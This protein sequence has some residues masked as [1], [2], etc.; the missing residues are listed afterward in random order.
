MLDFITTHAGDLSAALLA[1]L[2]AFSIIA[3]LTP[4]EADNRIVDALLKAVHALGLT[5]KV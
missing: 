1:L 2:G 4:T 3:R 5:R